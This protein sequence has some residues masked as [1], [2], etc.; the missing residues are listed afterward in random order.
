MKLTDAYKRYEDRSRT[1]GDVARKL[2]FAGIAIVWIFSGGTP[3]NARVIRIPHD[4]RWPAVLL[5]AGLAFDLLQY[6]W[7][8]F[9]WGFYHRYKEH[10]LGRGSEVDFGAPRPINYLTLIFFW[11]KLASVMAAYAIMVDYLARRLL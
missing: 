9:A 5:T 8:S 6:I 3:A 2:A 4:L 7:A 1:A 10:K 11:A